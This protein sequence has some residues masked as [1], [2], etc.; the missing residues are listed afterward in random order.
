MRKVIVNTFLTLDGVM[1]GPGLPDEDRE[2]G[3]ERGGWQMPYFDEVA[4]S[5]VQDGM[6]SSGGFLLGRKTY[7]I[8][9]EFWPNAPDDDPGAAMMNAIPKF[10]ASTTLEEPLAWNNSTLLKG[11]IAEA[12]NKLKQQPGKNLD[13]IGSGGFAQT[14]MHLDLVDEY[15][16]MIHPIVLGSG[17]RLFDGGLPIR[18]L[19]LVDTKTTSTGVVILIYRAAEKAGGDPA[20]G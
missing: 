15:Q 4:A 16:L 5:V 19:E 6:T 2:G 3:F 20:S 13:V 14:L 7:E 1:Q 10:V 18:T 9:A 17:K 12:V 8:F 11:D